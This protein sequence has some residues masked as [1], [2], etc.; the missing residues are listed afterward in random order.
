MP[1]Q[2]QVVQRAA[3]PY[4]AIQ[5]FVT[6]QTLGVVL[7]GLHPEVFAWLG[8]RGISPAG[9]PFWKYNVVDMERQL[10]VEVGVP[11]ALAAVGDDRVLAGVLPA[12]KYATLRHTGHPDSLADATAA[13]LD[14]AAQ[15]GLTWDLTRTDQGDRWGARLEIYETDPAQEP[16]MSQ[17][18]TEL[19]FR[20]AG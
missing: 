9:A 12:G 11:V 4:V 6:M 7:P 10:D 19:A 13:L 18:Q 3:Q 16:D 17:W 20:L 15:Q 2:P 5:A 8:A 1:G 14:W